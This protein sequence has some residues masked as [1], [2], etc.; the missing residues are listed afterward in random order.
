MRWNNLAKPWMTC[1]LDE[2]RKESLSF[3]QGHEPFSNH[4]P[5]DSRFEMEGLLFVTVKSRALRGRAD[6][7]FFAPAEAKRGQIP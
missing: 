6:I 4:K 1:C 7:T 2:M 5:A 3:E